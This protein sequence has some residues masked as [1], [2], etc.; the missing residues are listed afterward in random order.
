MTEISAP[1]L[2]EQKRKNAPGAIA[3]AGL[4]AGSLDLL[5]ACVLFGWDIPLFI[6]GGLLGRQIIIKSNHP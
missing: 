3:L 1:E 2:L 6:A 4:I 5:Q